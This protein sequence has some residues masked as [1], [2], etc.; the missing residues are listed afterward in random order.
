MGRGKRSDGNRGCVPATSA[1]RPRF[2]QDVTLSLPEVEGE[3]SLARLS[4]LAD[5]LHS[6]RVAQSAPALRQQL[7]LIQAEAQ[8]MI[9]KLD[10]R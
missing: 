1:P 9:V 6:D 2:E 7:K 8:A 5:G 4:R 10:S 3:P